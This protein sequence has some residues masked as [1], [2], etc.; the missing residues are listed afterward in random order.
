M[1]QPH[2][3][4]TVSFDEDRRPTIDV[5]ALLGVLVD[6]EFDYSHAKELGIEFSIEGI[7]NWFL[8]ETVD[9]ID[10]NNN[11]FLM[12]RDYIIGMANILIPKISEYRTLYHEH[13]R[14]HF[15]G[16]THG[17]SLRLRKIN[18]TD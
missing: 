5:D 9:N 17:G 11:F 10:T 6:A 14:Y 16:C 15:E 4:N 12:L 2:P 8:Y 7:V 18:S 1:H 13:L 3:S